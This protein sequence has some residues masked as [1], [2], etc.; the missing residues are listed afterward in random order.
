MQE[1]S[2][3]L[4]IDGD[5]SSF[6]AAAQAESAGRSSAA[7]IAAAY[8][9]TSVA[10][11]VATTAVKGFKAAMS[12]VST[13]TTIITQLITIVGKI[14][15]VYKNAGK[16]SE[17]LLASAK[18]YRDEAEGSG[19]DLSLYTVLKEQADKAGIAADEF[20]EK[21]KQF[22]EHKI[23]FDELAASVRSTADAMNG[24]AKAADAGS[25][26]TRYLADRAEADA[27]AKEYESRQKTEQAG[28]REI[29]E[30][31]RRAGGKFG[32]GA[33]AEKYWDMLMEAAGG[34]AGRVAEIFNSNRS[35]PN[36]RAVGV[37]GYGHDAIATQDA[38][39]RSTTARAPSL[40]RAQQG[41][42]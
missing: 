8:S 14:R 11:E 37:L 10:V 24:A 27:R 31:I 17:E 4:K 3:K 15:D 16:A 40:R 6:A 39:G 32:D 2:V 35:W 34:S 41:A 1:A 19:L 38:T 18:K 42:A 29:V 9:R 23:T 36:M 28:L 25:V 26:G 33:G 5:C 20:S 12:T 30:Q 7:S 21:L 13:V 22:K